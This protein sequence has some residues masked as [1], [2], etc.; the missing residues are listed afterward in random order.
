MTSTSEKSK[1]PSTGS[2][3]AQLT[4]ES[5][6]LAPMRRTCA[7]ESAIDFGDEE[8]ELNTCRSDEQ[9]GRAV[10][11]QCERCFGREGPRTWRGSDVLRH[12]DPAPHSMRIGAAERSA[13]AR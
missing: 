8:A 2:L 9:G 11:T 6:T 4:G 12:G 1:V 7:N 10:A 13:T 5:T 3:S